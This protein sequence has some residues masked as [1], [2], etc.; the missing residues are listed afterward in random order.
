MGAELSARQYY[1]GLVL[2]IPA[3]LGVLLLGQWLAAVF[4]ILLLG[5]RYATFLAE[6]RILQ[7]EAELAD[8]REVLHAALRHDPPTEETQ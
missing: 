8:T 7:V 4:F 3:L 1:V 2:A 6:R 5:Y